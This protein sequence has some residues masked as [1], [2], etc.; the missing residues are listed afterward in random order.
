MSGVKEGGDVVDAKPEKL[1]GTQ[2]LMRLDALTT[3]RRVLT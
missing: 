1:D 3:P 2:I